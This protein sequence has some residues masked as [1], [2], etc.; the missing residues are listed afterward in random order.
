M[1]TKYSY[2]K[3]RYLEMLDIVAPQSE[4][5]LAALDSVYVKCGIENFRDLRQLAA[6]VCVQP[7]HCDVG[8]AA[9]AISPL[10]HILNNIDTYEEYLKCGL[11][12]H[13]CDQ[14]ACKSHS[15]SHLLGGEIQDCGPPLY[16]KDC[17][18]EELIIQNIKLAI[19]EMKFVT[20][21]AKLLTVS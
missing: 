14:S 3:Y 8:E 16:C 11:P 15:Y 6:Y 19:T 12:L 9:A 7:V 4:N 10:Q 2:F 18:N 5:N 20:Y 1:P 21:L 17:N 13:L